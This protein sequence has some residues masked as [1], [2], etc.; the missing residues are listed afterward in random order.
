MVKIWL[1]KCGAS[2]VGNSYSS[3]TVT[4]IIDIILKMAF[5]CYSHGFP[6]RRSI[7]VDLVPVKAV[8]LIAPAASL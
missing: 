7:A 1:K 5:L 6:S 8:S 2:S 3:T 4:C